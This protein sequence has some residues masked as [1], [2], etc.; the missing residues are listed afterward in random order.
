MQD[1]EFIDWEDAFSNASY[2]P[3]GMSF[4][5]KWSKRAEIFRQSAKGS[6][7]VSY[8]EHPRACYDLFLPEGETRGLAMFVH[9]GYWLAFDKSSWSDLAEGALSLGWAVVL[10]S[11]VLA[12]EA[13][14]PEITNMIG[15]AI[16]TSCG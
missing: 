9:G 8:G 5:D 12:P 10:P 4:P 16:E 7:D 6:L 11:Y 1:S 13:S 14:L 2:I 15:R 3:D